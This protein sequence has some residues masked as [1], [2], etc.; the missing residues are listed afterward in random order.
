[1]KQAA[2]QWAEALP[3]G[4][5]RLGAMVFGR[6]DNER[7]Q[8]N[9][10]SVWYGGP[11]DRLNPDAA[12]NVGEVRRLLFAGQL[13]AAEM[14]ARSAL[15]STPRRQNP[16]QTLGDLD[17]V[18]VHAPG[19][20]SDYRRELD[21]DDAV[22]TVQYRRNGVHFRREILASA[23]DQVL[24]VRLTAD[25]PGQITCSANLT[26]R[27]LEDRSGKISG[28]TVYIDG[29][30]GPNGVSYAAVLKATVEGGTVRTLGDSVTVEG[31]D[32]VTL[33][34]AANTTF[35]IEQPQE[36]CVYQLERAAVRNYAL[37]R[38]EH[39][40]DHQRLFR[41]VELELGRNVSADLPT[42][43]RLSRLQEGADDPALAALYFQYGR[44]LLI[45]SSRPGTLPANLQGIWN[46][47]M[48]PSWESKYTININT[49]MNYWPAEVGN[50][51]ECHLPLFDLLER[52]RVTG[53]ETARRMYGCRGFV[54][55]HNTDIW[56]DSAPVDASPAISVWPMG[57]AWLCLHLW[58][59]Y[60]FG[61]DRQFLAERA[62]PLMKEAAEFLLDYL[63]ED[64]HGQLV[65]G[66]SGS[67]ENVY[68]LPNGET[69]A[70]CMGPSMD[71]QIIRELFAA[72]QRA[73]EILDCD[74]EFRQQ[75]AANLERLPAPQI[76]KHGKL[77]EWLEDYEE[78]QPGH[79]HISHLFA[80]HP[81]TQIDPRR[82]PALAQAA[83]VSLER[84]LAHGG[85]HTGWSRAWIINFWARLLDAEQA[86]A[87]VRALLA[88]ST[89]P[90]L[91]DTH[92][93]FQI[94]GN[95]GGAAGIAELLLQSHAGE[96][97][98]LPALPA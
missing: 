17:V 48:T 59:H 54:A 24:A 45:A 92:P 79:R 5:G 81:G 57:G 68:R 30:V 38:A 29:Q 46:E 47:S 70:M 39:V 14:L 75:L 86:H 72:L 87:N 97:H 10:D 3:V 49:E 15:L 6:V 31:A 91:F 55:H 2:R 62:Y 11:R 7:I 84:R 32:A 89:L 96:L 85:G 66:P 26:R 16:Y 77:M 43:E 63:V 88:K 83:R 98:L 23:V 60:Q 33:L 94:D 8:L 41:R 64:E 74:S 61:G 37:L 40:A 58:E 80:V 44:Y 82:T 1:Y 95:F 52:V 4:N 27:P 51:A 76:G 36:A 9:E 22:V 56:A 42:N 90:N 65:S 13:R 19:E 67:P 78:V 73:G 25:Q 18:F 12:S 93:P 53:R 69:S 21:L 28:D 50:L 20:T 34:V 35:R 71:T